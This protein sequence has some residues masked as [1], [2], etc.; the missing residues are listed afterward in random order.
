MLFCSKLPSRF[1]AKVVYTAIF[2]INKTLSFIIEFE[3]PIQKWS[4]K[5]GSYEHL[6]VFGYQAYI[7][8]K[9]G[10][11]QPRV[12]SGIFIGYLKRVKGYKLRILS[13]DVKGYKKCI[14]SG[15]VIFKNKTF[16]YLSLDEDNSQSQVKLT[17]LEIERGKCKH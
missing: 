9:K 5:V 10:K 17:N 12:L 2:L 14:T 16:P 7:Q 6:R 11:L 8:V 3:T 15:D 4:S 13:S 1:W